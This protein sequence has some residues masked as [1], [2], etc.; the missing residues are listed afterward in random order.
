MDLRWIIAFSLFYIILNQPDFRPLCRYGVTQIKLVSVFVDYL[1]NRPQHFQRKGDVAKDERDVT[2]QIIII[3][4]SNQ[5]IGK[6]T[7][8]ELAKRG[9]R[10][11]MAC[12]NLHRAEMAKQDILQDVPNA[13]LETLQ[14]DLADS[15]SVREFSV[16]IHERFPHIDVLINNAGVSRNDQHLWR[17]KDGFEEQMGVNYLNMFL[18]TLSLLDLLGKA[19]KSRIVTVASMSFQMAQL[20]VDN[21]NLDCGLEKS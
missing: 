16:I 5:G 8:L 7:A 11:I 21:L 20:D 18:L 12:R 1:W 3:T 13:K 19:R 2:D 4:G 14:L 17:T 6:Q 10:V 9:A 15:K